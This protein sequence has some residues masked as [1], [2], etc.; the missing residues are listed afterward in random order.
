MARL[1]LMLAQLSM[2]LYPTRMQSH[3]LR[4]FLECC[5]THGPHSSTSE[6]WCHTWKVRNR[7]RAWQRLLWGAFAPRDRRCLSMMLSF[8]VTKACQIWESPRWWDPM[9]TMGWSWGED[10]GANES[11]PLRGYV[12]KRCQ[13]LWETSSQLVEIPLSCNPG[14]PIVQSIARVANDAVRVP[15]SQHRIFCRH[16][17]THRARNSQWATSRAD[18]ALIS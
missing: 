7:I 17:K 13:S 4:E 18:Q 6:T 8:A 3:M 5:M 1:V 16:L 10:V 12:L 9:P 14:I 15:V 11:R 2:C